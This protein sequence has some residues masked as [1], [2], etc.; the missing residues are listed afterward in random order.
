MESWYY[1]T[2]LP[3]KISPL[4]WFD[5]VLT[6]P[7]EMDQSQYGRTRRALAEG[8]FDGE[9]SCFVHDAQ[10]PA[11]LLVFV[12]QDD[13]EIALV[14]VRQDRRRQG[15]AMQ[16][17]ERGLEG[18]RREAVRRVM[19]SSVSSGNAAVVHLLEA[20]G[21]VGRPQG[22]LRMRRSL[23]GPL[24]QVSVPEGFALRT[25]RP[26]EEGWWVRLKNACFPESEPWTLEHFRQEF[27]AA[28]YFEYERIFVAVHEERMVGTASA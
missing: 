11:G 8:A 23:T 1:G 17:M 18:L 14:A 28:A 12:G 10:G 3:Y 5:R 20:S 2:K 27:C 15:L 26:G 22:S 13:R 21:F 6:P 4:A 24:P 9:N 19:A 7:S 16:L 25:L